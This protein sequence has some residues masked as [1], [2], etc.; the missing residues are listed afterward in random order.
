ML[1]HKQ[2][3]GNQLRLVP[4]FLFAALWIWHAVQALFASVFIFLRSKVSCMYPLL[5][6]NVAFQGIYIL[7]KSF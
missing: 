6:R 2:K 4:L 3:K 5:L 1:L 7:F